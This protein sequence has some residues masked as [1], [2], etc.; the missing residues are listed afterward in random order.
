MSRGNAGVLEGGLQKTARLFLEPWALC[1]LSA[2]HCSG[3][4]RLLKVHMQP[5]LVLLMG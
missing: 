2:S 1:D 5:W 3:Q 4:F